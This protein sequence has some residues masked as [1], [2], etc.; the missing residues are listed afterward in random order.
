MQKL[1]VTLSIFLLGGC[2][3]LDVSQLSKADARRLDCPATRQLVGDLAATPNGLIVGEMHGTNESRLAVLEL[4][5]A[6]LEDGHTVSLALEMPGAAVRRDTKRALSDDFWK[7]ARADGRSSKAML[8]LI[9]DLAPLRRSGAVKVYGF[10]DPTAGVTQ[11][12]ARSAQN[13]LAGARPGDV[14][15]VL[16]GNVHA[17]RSGTAVTIGSILADATTVSVL[18]REPGVV[19]ACMPAC[20]EH[21]IGATAALSVGSHKAPKAFG[22]DY[23][24]VVQRYSPSAPALEQ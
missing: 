15:I 3:H 24:I 16:T 17:R 8:T 21:P 1:L 7:P 12:E 20:G 10:S 22:Y 5:C 9:E 19:W 6:A 18:S 4:I 2:V 14:L 13:I 11:W 23:A